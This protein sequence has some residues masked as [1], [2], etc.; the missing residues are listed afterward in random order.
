MYVHVLNFPFHEFKLNISIRYD[1]RFSQSKSP[2]GWSTSRRRGILN[3]G[4]TEP[5]KNIKITKD[6]KIHVE[7]AKFIYSFL[8]AQNCQTKPAQF[9]D[10]IQ[11]TISGTVFMSIVKVGEYT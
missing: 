6:R 9:K 5:V 1:V 3:D 11:P 4:G 2:V 10:L 7:M 8:D